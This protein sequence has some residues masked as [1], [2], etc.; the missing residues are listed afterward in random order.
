MRTFLALILLGFSVSAFSGEEFIPYKILKREAVLDIKVVFDVEVPLVNK[1]LP[2]AEDLGKISKY[3]VSKEPK[4]ERSFVMFFLPHMKRDSGAFATA[5]HN[6]GMK[7][8]ILDY[9]LFQYPEYRK[10]VK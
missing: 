7:V 3:L 8:E 1:R 10:F 2:N 4:R 6:P 9:M 5:H